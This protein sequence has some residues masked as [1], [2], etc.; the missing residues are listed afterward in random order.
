ML[1]SQATVEQ[2]GLLKWPAVREIMRAH[3]ANEADY[4]DLLLVLMN[5][6][7]WS[8]MFLDGESAADVGEA[9]SERT[10]AA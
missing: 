1:L 10:L 9:L 8:R 3:D 2:R 6:E 5:L 7:I 4:T